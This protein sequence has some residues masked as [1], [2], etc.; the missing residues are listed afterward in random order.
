M[1]VDELQFPQKFLRC[2]KAGATVFEQGET[3]RHLYVVCQGTVHIVRRNGDGASPLAVLRKGEIFG[4]MALVE[5]LPRSATALAAENTNLLE[6]DHALFN[7]I[8]TQQPAFALHVLR[9]MS[10]R[11]RRHMDEVV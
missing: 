6:I 11:L 5:S 2:Y 3:G 10:R 4:E 7:Y 9:T 1:G 8:V